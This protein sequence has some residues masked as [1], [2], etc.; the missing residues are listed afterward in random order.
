MTEKKEL[1]LQVSD[2]K[3]HLQILCWIGFYRALGMHNSNRAQSLSMTW[4]M[5][6]EMTTVEIEAEN[7]QSS[8]G[9]AGVA[10]AVRS[11]VRQSS[12]K[13]NTDD[14][15]YRTWSDGKAQNEG[16]GFRGEYST[17]QQ[18]IGYARKILTLVE[19]APSASPHHGDPEV[20]LVKT[21]RMMP[22][23]ARE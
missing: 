23:C 1:F 9:H 2:V 12:P 13:N 20:H 17:K 4:H 21:K 22:F 8:M 3:G 11:S 15:T 16:A 18:G 19:M 14:D 5:E 6:I 7:A 10:T